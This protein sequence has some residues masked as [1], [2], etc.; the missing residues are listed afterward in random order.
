VQALFRDPFEDPRG[1]YFAWTGRL[2]AGG[3]A[4]AG[5]PA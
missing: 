2:A 3:R 4:S 1:A 5:P